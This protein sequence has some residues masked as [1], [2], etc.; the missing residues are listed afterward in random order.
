MKKQEKPF[1][2]HLLRQ[3]AILFVRGYQLL[4]SPL[5]PANCRYQPT[6]SQYAI[7]A[8]EK[9][10][11]LRGL[12]LAVKRIGRCHPFGGEGFDPVPEGAKKKNRKR[13]TNA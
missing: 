12:I 2:R 1:F 4:I 11:I 8:I 6:C 5:L 7:D 3:C 9:H 13:V 10:G